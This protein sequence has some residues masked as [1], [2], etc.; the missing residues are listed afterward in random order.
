[1]S[2]V[3]ELLTLMMI[4]CDC[5]VGALCGQCRNGSGVSVLLNKC[6]SCSDGF[7]TLI[8]LLST[9]NLCLFTVS[10]NIAYLVSILTLYSVGI[11]ITVFVGITLLDRPF[12]DLAY[13]LLFYV[14]VRI[15]IEFI[16]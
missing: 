12:P 4:I 13:P 16:D 9:T 2:D 7:L 15:H 10:H 5:C 11:D 14:Q 6:V 1:M 3:V 8:F